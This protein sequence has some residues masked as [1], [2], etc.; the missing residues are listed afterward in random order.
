[1][2]LELSVQQE[3]TLSLIMLRAVRT[4]LVL[5]FRSASTASTAMLMPRRRSIGFM[6]AATALHPSAKMARHNT[7]EVV[8]PSPAMSLVCCQQTRDTCDV[9]ERDRPRRRRRAA[10]KTR[11][12]CLSATHLIGNL[13][14]EL[15]AEVVVAVL[16][17]DALGNGNTVLGDLWW[18]KRLLQHNVASLGAKG[19][20]QPCGQNLS[21]RAQRCDRRNALVQRLL[22]CLHSICEL[23]HTGQH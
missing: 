10:G 22:L 19:H 4:I 14:H 23:V 8:V 15:R 21:G 7:V 13:P 6:P 9:S 17:L 16:E 2:H 18:A 1:M 3:A 11:A 20:L 5:A 12:E